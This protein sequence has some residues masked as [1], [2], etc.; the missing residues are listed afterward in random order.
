MLKQSGFKEHRRH[1]SKPETQQTE[2]QSIRMCQQRCPDHTFKLW[3][4]S[5]MTRPTTQAFS[6]FAAKTPDFFASVCSDG[7]PITTGVAG[8]FQAWSYGGKR[9][10]SG[11]SSHLC[12]LLMSLKRS[13]KE[14]HLTR[15]STR[16]RSLAS[17]GNEPLPLG[18]LAHNQRDLSVNC[19]S[20][21]YHIYTI[22]V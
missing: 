6:R 9:G 11:T 17:S 15:P 4:A 5:R 16:W 1:Y 14:K 19:I 20:Q 2:H 21:K 22:C 3:K 18:R 8:F 7:S 13:Q 12:Q 10:T